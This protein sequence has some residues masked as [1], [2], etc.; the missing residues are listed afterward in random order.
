MGRTST[1]IMKFTFGTRSFRPYRTSN[2]ESALSNRLKRLYC[3]LSRKPV[4]PFYHFADT[5]NNSTTVFSD[6]STDSGVGGIQETDIVPD[7]T[8]HK[9][10]ENESTRTSIN[11]NY[12]NTI[13]FPVI[14][15]YILEG[16]RAVV[17]RFPQYSLKPKFSHTSKIQF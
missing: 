9:I 10:S 16:N 14:D 13:L 15:G 3:F 5:S 7:P 12:I 2:K 11:Y 17:V 8:S 6:L 4:W 1:R